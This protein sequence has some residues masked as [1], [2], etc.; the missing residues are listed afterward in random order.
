M[1][2][3]WTKSEEIKMKKPNECDMVVTLT[4]PYVPNCI[5]SFKLNLP[6]YLTEDCFD[7]GLIVIESI[8]MVDE[9]YVEER[10]EE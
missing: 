9:R 4:V 5:E 3:K 10:E 8:Q 2:R 7:E 6:T 1:A